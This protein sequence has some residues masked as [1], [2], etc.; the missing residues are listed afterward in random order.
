M[1]ECFFSQRFGMVFYE[2]EDFCM[3]LHGDGFCWILERCL[4][5]FEC[6]VVL[7][8]LTKIRLCYFF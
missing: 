3:F 2:S 6:F 1:L 8:L 7:I 5:Y 4:L